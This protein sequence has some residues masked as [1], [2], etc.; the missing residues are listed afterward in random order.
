MGVYTKLNIPSQKECYGLIQEMGMMDHIV[1]HSEQ[2]CRV[3]LCLADNLCH[4]GIDLNLELIQAS[5]LLHDITK[6]RSFRTK[7]NH[8]ETGG[9]FLQERGF[10]EV[11]HVIAQHVKLDSYVVSNDLVEAEI[12]NYADKRVLHDQIVSLTDRMSYILERYADGIKSRERILGLWSKSKD[13]E[14]RI[15]SFLPFL[16]QALKQMV[17][18]KKFE[19]RNTK[20][21]K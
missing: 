13:L 3:A 6:T 1:D 20:F 4:A 7:E 9:K 5:A 16:P 19:A 18:S 12:V 14:K 15:F 21:P 11:G 10:S 8:A 17:E 2:V